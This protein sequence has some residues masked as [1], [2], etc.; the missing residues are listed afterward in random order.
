MGQAVTQQKIY[1]AWSAHRKHARL[2][3][4]GSLC[5]RDNAAGVILFVP[6][7]DV[8]SVRLAVGVCVLMRPPRLVCC[9]GQGS[10]TLVPQQRAKSPHSR[11]PLAALRVSM[12]VLLA[13]DC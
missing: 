9:C 7:V 13:L 4:H 8:K 12:R 3:G 6:G 11:R 10:F 1:L 2:L 5:C